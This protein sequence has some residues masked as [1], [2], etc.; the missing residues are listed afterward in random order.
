MLTDTCLEE[1][2]VGKGWWVG[3]GT[4]VSALGGALRLEMLSCPKLSRFSMGP[5]A[6]NQ[7]T[8]R[9]HSL[10]SWGLTSVGIYVAG[11]LPSGPSDFLWLFFPKSI[12]SCWREALE[13][14]V[15]LFKALS[16]R[17]R[18]SHRDVGQLFLW[19]TSNLLLPGVR[20]L[21]TPSPDS[22]GTLFLYLLCCLCLYMWLL[23]NKCALLH[24]PMLVY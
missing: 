23:V 4:Y 3:S 8:H 11:S 13:M 21:S 22:P 7:A 16:S 5:F 15:N 6:G 2:L 18:K 19:K 1:N 24:Y 14:E 9:S 20:V 10:Q 17:W 12:S